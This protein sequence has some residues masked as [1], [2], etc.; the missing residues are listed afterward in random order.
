[1]IIKS[2]IMRREFM[3]KISI[4]LVVIL[5]AM[6]ALI[7]C[8]NKE[9]SQTSTASNQGSGGEVDWPKKP[10]K[11]IIP[12]DAGGGT[13]LSARA[14]QPYLE[15]EL[16]VSVVVENKPGAGGWLAW[17]ELASGKPDGYTI[18]YMNFP[19]VIAGYLNPSLNR[20]ENLDSFSFISGH[21][22][23]AGVI[24]VRP[25]DDRF[26]DINSLVD[27]AKKNELSVNSS[28][29]G[30]ANHFVGVQ[31]MDQLDSKF[32]FVQT[33]G[34][35]EAIPSV[36]GGHV[37]VLIAGIGE[38]KDLIDNGKLKPIAVFGSE[39]VPSL[40][41]VPTLNEAVGADT[42]KFLSRG[43]AGPKGMDPSIV[44]KLQEA[45]A[46]AEQNA[47]HVK[48]INDMG[49]E[50]DST[51]GEEYVTSLKTQEEAISKLKDVFGW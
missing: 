14:L 48:K 42:N 40:P 18:G 23:D 17:S 49:M 20:Q 36:L 3:K 35:A 32:R 15:K 11:L 30:S 31:M 25:D 24:A 7:G 10:I 38:V 1:M 34:T 28:G 29:V 37:D 22:V 12:F 9:T 47:E 21:V 46:K 45:I 5:F 26:A 2:K 13:D 33:D 50:I 39:S 41:N 19:N 6:V 4:F 27:Y 16:G 43:I 51:S 44:A 8:A